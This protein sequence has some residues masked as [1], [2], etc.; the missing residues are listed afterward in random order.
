VLVALVLVLTAVWP[1]AWAGAQDDDGPAMEEL[2]PDDGGGGDGGG[3]GGGGG[4]QLPP[5]APAEIDAVIGQ[6]AEPVAAAAE[7]N[8]AAQFLIALLGKIADLQNRFGNAAPPGEAIPHVVLTQIADE[9]HQF[10]EP[11]AR[12]ICDNELVLPGISEQVQ[13][14]LSFRWWYPLVPPYFFGWLFGRKSICVN[15]LLEQATGQLLPPCSIAI[16]HFE[17]WYTSQRPSTFR[18]Y[19]DA[20]A[21][22]IAY[23]MGQGV[24]YAIAWQIYTVHST[25]MCVHN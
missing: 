3:D 21:D 15:R 22:S 17:T 6:V 19:N 25:P 2:L 1:A 4:E 7:N 12:Q 11:Y 8:A 13:A 14:Q 10:L 5:E 9:L 16:G 24:P 20:Q 18:S 23:L